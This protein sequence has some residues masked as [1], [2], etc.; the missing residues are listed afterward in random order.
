VVEF[1]GQAERYQR[2]DEDGRSLNRSVGHA[3]DQATVN[4]ILGWLNH[5]RVY[6]TQTLD[7]PGGHVRLSFRSPSRTKLSAGQ[8]RLGD[9]EYRDEIACDCEAIRLRLSL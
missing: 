6:G 3:L 1:Q 2:T 4:D 5:S 8:R 9:I 7:A